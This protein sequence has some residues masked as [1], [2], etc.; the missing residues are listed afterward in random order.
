MAKLKRESLA[1]YIK[2][3]AALSAAWHL[4]GK[5]IEDMSVDMGGSFESRKNILGETSVSDTGYTPSLAVS[6]YYAD[7]SDG[8]YDFLLDLALGR[9]SGDDAKATMLEVVIVD[10]SAES[11]LAYQEDCVIEITSYGGNTEGF[12]IEYTVHPNG[13]RKKGTVT[14]GDDKQPT[15]QAD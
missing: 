1:H 13:N 8:I 12:G 11:H 3:V 2:P 7:P 14:I 15:F 5:D 6:P 9:K 4:I 10:T